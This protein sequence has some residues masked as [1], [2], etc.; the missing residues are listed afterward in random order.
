MG[1]MIILD[2]DVGFPIK[3]T[4]SKREYM[5]MR[6][7]LSPEIWVSFAPGSVKILE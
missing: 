5:T 6:I 3:A 4:L 7:D 2:I 1:S